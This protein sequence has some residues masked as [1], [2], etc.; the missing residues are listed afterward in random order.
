M[1]FEAMVNRILL[2]KNINQEKKRTVLN[3]RVILTFKIK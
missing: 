2:E 1:V 3:S